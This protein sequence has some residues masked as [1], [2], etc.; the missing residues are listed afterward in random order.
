MVENLK[1]ISGIHINIKYIVA[2]I[3][4]LLIVLYYCKEKILFEDLLKMLV[5]FLIGTA[6][7]V[8]QFIIKS[9]IA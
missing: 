8:S 4:V 6:V 2:F 1:K 7:K 9:Y 5:P 3:I